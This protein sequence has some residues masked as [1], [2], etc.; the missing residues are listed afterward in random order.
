VHGEHVPAIWFSWIGQWELTKDQIF[1]VLQ[2]L[3]YA[4]SRSGV[5][6]GLR[7]REGAEVTPGRSAER[8]T[9]RRHAVVGGDRLVSLQGGPIDYG[10]SEP[11]EFTDPVVNIIVKSYD[12]KGVSGKSGFFYNLSHATPSP[13]KL[14]QNTLPIAGLTVLGRRRMRS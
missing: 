3:D 14:T 2:L 6:A 10:D 5:W 9:R 8:A 1:A 12:L 13:S 4:E 11:L 7:A